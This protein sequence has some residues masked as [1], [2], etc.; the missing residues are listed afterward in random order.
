[1]KVYFLLEGR[2]TEPKIYSSWLSHLI[3]QLKR[4]NSHNDKSE[5]NSYFLFSANGY[6]LII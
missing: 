6:P 3:P 4:I 5:E 2:R 1:M